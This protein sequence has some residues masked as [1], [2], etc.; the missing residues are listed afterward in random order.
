MPFLL[1]TVFSIKFV[2]Q[3]AIPKISTRIKKKRK[4]ERK[5]RGIQYIA[6]G[7][8]YMYT[9]DISKYMKYIFYIKYIK[10]IIKT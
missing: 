8:L 6:G 3:S 5:K 1:R 4:N 2:L 10:Y 7:F 9:V